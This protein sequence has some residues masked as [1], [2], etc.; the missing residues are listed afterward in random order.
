VR[1]PAP[2]AA[3]PLIAAIRDIPLRDPALAGTR[4]YALD[5][6]GD[7]DAFERLLAAPEIAV[8][9]FATWPAL[10]GH[11]LRSQLG[12]DA[13]LRKPLEMLVAAVARGGLT[14]QA[15]GSACH[16]IL[17]DERLETKAR[18]RFAKDLEAALSE[19]PDARWVDTML[20]ACDELIKTGGGTL[21]SRRDKS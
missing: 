16:D 1:R 7:R 13:K 12:S 10:L 8:P 17:R 4:L 19:A 9:T 21:F 18:K 14:V 20:D 5:C 15:F 3:A 2:A 6:L 11:V